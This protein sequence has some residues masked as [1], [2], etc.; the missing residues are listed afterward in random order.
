MYLKQVTFE[1]LG[2][3]LS[4]GGRCES[5]IRARIG[6]AMV[7]FGKMRK[8]LTNPSLDAQ[9]RLRILRCYIWYGLLYGRES[10]KLSADMKKKLE[11]AEMGLLR[12]MNVEGTI[13]GKADKP[14]SA[15][16]AKHA[17]DPSYHYKKKAV[18]RV[19]A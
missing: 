6:M 8:L 1:Y 12:R 4:E 5:E 11:A 19:C 2:S 7:K 14:G 16:D 13:D 3:V 10:W 17:N 18:P 15:T 9:L